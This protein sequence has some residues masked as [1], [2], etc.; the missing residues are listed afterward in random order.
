VVARVAAHSSFGTA[1][2]SSGEWQA[3][4][5]SLELGPLYAEIKAVEGHA[6]HPPADPRMLMALWLYATFEGVG[7]ARQLDKLCTAHVAYQWICGDVSMNYHSLADFR[8]DHSDWLQGQVVHIVAVLRKEGLVDLNQVGQD[9]MRVRASAGSGSFKRQPKLDEFLQEAQ[10]QWDQLQQEFEQN[11]A[12]LNARQRAARK[13]AA[14]ERLERLNRAKEECQQLAESREKRKKGDGKTA[15]ASM[16]DPEA[17]KMKMADGGYRPA[18]NVQFATTL[19][20]LVII[21]VDVINSG[22]DGGQME[23]MV[24][25]I[26]AQQQTL[27]GEYYTDGGFSTKDDIE[28]VEQRG[29]TVYTP[30]KEADKQ[31]REGKDPY[32]PRSGEGPQLTAWRQRMGTEEAKEKYKQRA[33]CEWSNAQCRNHNLWQFTVRGLIKA[34]AVALWHALV[35]NLLRMVALRAEHAAATA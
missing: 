26:E 4:R 6:G 3:A 20:T 15:R 27:P 14:R 9:G 10:L 18:Y 19:D 34:K 35:Q 21:G 7:S 16:T 17:R 2:V 25:Q 24:Q 29:V 22:S 1:L 33:K 23:P 28:D 8:T 31:K 32:A 11:P 5:E 13:R 30:V 12:E